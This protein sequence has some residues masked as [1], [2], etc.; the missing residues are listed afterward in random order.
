MSTGTSCS[1]L[2]LP[3]PETAPHWAAEDHRAPSTTPS[4]AVPEHRAPNADEGKLHLFNQQASE[5]HGGKAYDGLEM[6]STPASREP[7]IHARKIC[8]LTQTTPDPCPVPT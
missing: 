8:D 1:N 4:P 5:A 3:D 2:N 6:N 7:T